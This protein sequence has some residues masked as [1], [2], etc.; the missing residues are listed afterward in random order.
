M[1]VFYRLAAQCVQV[2]AKFTKL[3]GARARGGTEIAFKF[4][5]T[6]VCWR[7]CSN[8]KCTSETL[9]DLRV[10]LARSYDLVRTT[11]AIQSIQK[12]TTAVV[13]CFSNGVQLVTSI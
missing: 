6:F 12:P 5:V 13:F 8:A 4:L 10:C 2:V 3:V 1:H 7:V 9:T 11:D